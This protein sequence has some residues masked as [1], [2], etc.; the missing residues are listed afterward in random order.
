MKPFRWRVHRSAVVGTCLFGV[1]AGGCAT[2]GHRIERPAVMPVVSSYSARLHVAIRS[3]QGRARG[4]V[5]VAFRRPN[6]LRLE[7]PG[8]VGARLVAVSTKST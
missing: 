5:I 3:P 1:V 8:P 6:L 7:V 2:S 4:N